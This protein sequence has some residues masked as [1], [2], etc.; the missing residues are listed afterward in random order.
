M[1]SSDASSLDPEI[2]SF[3][4]NFSIESPL[5]HERFYEINAGLRSHCPYLHSE[6]GDFWVLSRYQDGAAVARDGKGVSNDQI[7][8]SFYSPQ[9]RPHMRPTETDPPYQRHLRH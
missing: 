7:G 3:L 8:G 6:R 2:R 5:W 4:E 1:P 9:D